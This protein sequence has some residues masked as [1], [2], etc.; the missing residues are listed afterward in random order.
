MTETLAEALTLER[1]VTRLK[2]RLVAAPG[3]ALNPLVPRLRELIRNGVIGTPYWA[4]APAPAW[5]GRDIECSSNPAWYF[6]EGAGP[7]RDRAVYALHLL[8]ALFGPVRRV[9]AMQAVTVKRRSWSGRPFMVMAPDNVVAQLDFGDGLLATVGA[10]WCAGGA[11]AEPYQF[12]V[13]G[14]EG[15]IESRETLGAW[16]TACEVRLANGQAGTVSLEPQETPALAAAH[17]RLN[18]PIWADLLHLFGCMQ[19]GKEVDPLVSVSHARHIV[20]VLEA[21]ERAA[22]TGQTQGL[23]TGEG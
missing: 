22:E 9:T 11:R 8:T 20:E 12:G 21:V 4:H 10:Q 19:L 17:A 5:G 14:L 3:Q 16:P 15:A 13:Y 1:E 7:F 2:V 18:A 23:E 6:R